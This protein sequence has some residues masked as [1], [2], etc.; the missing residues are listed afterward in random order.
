M[1]AGEV[2]AAEIGR[3]EAGGFQVGVR[4]FARWRTVQFRLL[5]TSV[6]PSKLARVPLQW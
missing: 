3:G 1:C 6:A 2:G 5:F 4:R